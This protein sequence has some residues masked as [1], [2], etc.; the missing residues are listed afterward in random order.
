MCRGMKRIGI[1]MNFVSAF[2]PFF[3][4]MC[5]WAGLMSRADEPEKYAN[6]PISLQLVGRRYED[7]KVVEAMEYIQEML[8]L[9]W[10]EY[11]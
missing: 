10:A 11:V 1:I 8:G 2:Q 7:E 4:M 5:V 3:C 9:P 6:A